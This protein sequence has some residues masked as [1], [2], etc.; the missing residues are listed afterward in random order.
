M[1]NMRHAL[2]MFND[3]LVSGNTNVRELFS[4]PGTGY[5][6]ALHQFLKSIILGEH[7]YYRSERSHVINLYDF[8]PTIGG[9]HFHAL[10]L[11]SFLAAR[12][13]AS[14]PMGRGYVDLNRLF[15]AAEEVAIRRTVVRDTL[16]RLSEF[17]L[18]EYDNYSRKDIDGAAY[19]TIT[20]AGLY[21]VTEL[22]DDFVYLDAVLVDTPIFDDGLVR[23]FKATIGR[24][25]LPTRVER[26][27]RFI[28][29][30]RSAE[31]IEHQENPQFAGTDLANH[32]FG[33]Q[34]AVDHQALVAKIASGV[35][36]VSDVSSEY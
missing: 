8:D 26:V 31:R 3:F 24:F 11:L 29:Y 36:R 32:R 17:R 33:D 22:F 28:N 15:L 4:V 9:S 20:P 7:R 35:V 19:V 1:N 13:D 23:H 34:L 6:I 16:L 12:K 18:I 14:S 30:L 10:R 21:Y 2:D 5:Q 27:G 25:D